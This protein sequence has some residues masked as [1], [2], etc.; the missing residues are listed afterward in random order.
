[1][2]LLFLVRHGQASFGKANYDQLSPLGHQQA[3]W[4]GEY[5]AQR[6]VSFKRAIAGSLV[7][8]QETAQSLLKAMN[9]SQPIDTHAGL[10]EY[11]GEALYRAATNGRD[12]LA[13]QRSDYRDYWRT[14]KAAMHA[15]A[16]DSL[17]GDFETWSEFG[18]RTRAALDQAAAGL[19]ADEAALVVSSGGALSRAL[20]DILQCPGAMAVEFNLQ[21]RNSGVSELIVGRSGVGSARLVTFN[22]IPHLD[23]PER[24][25]SITF[26]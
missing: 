19:G 15:W 23:T 21:Y 6:G 17:K 26:A 5:F 4:L 9:A 22:A 14:L 18:A 24:R 13:H 12:V 20:V 11:D 25:A 10:N 3:A 7:R 16:D 8:Q 1:M 2:A